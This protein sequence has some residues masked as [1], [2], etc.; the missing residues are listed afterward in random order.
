MLSIGLYFIY[1]AI[2]A[3]IIGEV[4]VAGYYS[5]TGIIGVG[6]SIYMVSMLRRKASTQNIYPKVMTTIE[7]N[8]C[9]LKKLRK[10]EKGDYVL[11]NVEN[12][13]KC[14]QPMEITAIYAE[15]ITE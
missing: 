5:I 9:G 2:Q 6:M 1:N 14:N 10:F 11:K 4:E 13:L 3:Y 8:I 12:C 7:C 15:K